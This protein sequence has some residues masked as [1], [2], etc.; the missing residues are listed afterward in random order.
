VI[1]SRLRFARF[2]LTLTL[3]GHGITVPHADAQL[4]PSPD[5]LTIY[6]AVLKVNWLANAN[7]AGTAAGK[8]GVNNI[9]PDGSMDYPTAVQWLAADESPAA[10]SDSVSP[11]PRR[12]PL[13]RLPG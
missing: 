1:K 5:G 8:F 10:R 6:D 7:L 12:T 13:R 2:V 9:N 4:I 3:S 11:R